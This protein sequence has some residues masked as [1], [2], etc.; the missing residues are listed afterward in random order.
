MTF[1]PRALIAVAAYASLYAVSLLRL[2]TAPGFE[3]GESLA[4]LLVFGVLFSAIAWIATRGARPPP[5]AVR[6]PPR[7]TAVLILYLAAFAV[8]VLGIGLSAVREALGV[9][10]RQ[11]LAI[12][13]LKLASMVVAPAALFTLLGY[14]WR[15]QLRWREFGA[16]GW[17]CFGV[18]ALLLA[19]LQAVAGRGLQTLAASDASLVA[20]MLAAPLALAWESIE[21]GL[22]EEFLFRALLQTRLSAW[23]RSETAGIVAMTLLFGLAHA[24]GYVLRGAHAAEGLADAP[25]PL[26]AAAYAVVVVSPLGLMFGVLWSRT[27]NLWLL[28]LLHGWTDLFPNLVAFMRTWQ[29]G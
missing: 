6:D 18:M 26:T 14:P 2:A 1:S 22:C 13:G 21:A 11:A 28:V 17:R 20:I 27:R 8:L 10:P 25:D 16:V 12:L 24:P 7:E 5:S 15:D 29:L 3:A 9:A 19:L 4:A 23:L